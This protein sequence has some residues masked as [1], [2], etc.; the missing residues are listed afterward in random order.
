MAIDAGTIPVPSHQR[1]RLLALRPRH[2]SV[3]STP[4]SI[5]R[6]RLPP[7]ARSRRATP[8]TSSRPESCRQSHA[9]T[10]RDDGLPVNSAPLPADASTTRKFYTLTASLR[11]IYDDNVTGSNNNQPASLETMLSPSI[12]VDFPTPEGEF[13][14]RYTFNLT[15]YSVGP[16]GDNGS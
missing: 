14:G 2:W 6:L 9:R 1:E 11:E 12:L 13:T 8:L 5:P 15:Y 4:A 16:N 10:A 3:A 7:R